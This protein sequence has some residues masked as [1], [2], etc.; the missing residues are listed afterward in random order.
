[1]LTSIQKEIEKTYQIVCPFSVEDF[2]LNEKERSR[3]LKQIPSLVDSEET[4]LIR[5]KEEEIDIGLLYN[6]ELLD[7]SR[8]FDW[9]EIQNPQN[10]FCVGK[11]G[12]LIEGVSHF[13]YF[14]WK[15]EQKQPLTQL[16]LELQAEIDKFI[17]LSQTTDPSDLENL[18]DS[19][20]EEV[21]WIPALGSLEK[22]RYQTAAKLAFK[23]CHY[24][25]KTY[26]YSHQ[27]HAIYSEIR[28]FYRMSQAEKIRWIE[29]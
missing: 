27:T 25:K 22:S 23:Y 21:N 12:S 9:K 26:F 19:L 10:Q 18:I 13:V 20:Y 15:L 1:M 16:E 28:T 3:Y 17:L 14:L 24:L 5:Q 11:L 29:T 7:W 6:P 2:L 4:L 8:N